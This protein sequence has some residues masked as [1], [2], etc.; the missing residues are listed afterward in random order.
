MLGF[1][2]IWPVHLFIHLFLNL[3][4]KE[5]R[6]KIVDFYTRF[7]EDSGKGHQHVNFASYLTFLK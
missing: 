3:N 6:E 2:F 5:L 1:E 4:L 7:E